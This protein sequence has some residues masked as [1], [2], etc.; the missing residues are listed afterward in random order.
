[1]N[2]AQISLGQSR[3]AFAPQGKY[4]M[5]SYLRREQG[6]G[7]WLSGFL[8]PRSA[9]IKITSISQDDGPQRKHQ[10]GFKSRADEHQ[11]APTCSPKSTYFI[12]RGKR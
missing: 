2:L 11:L 8:G 9:I 4:E 3:L 7:I 6:S 10:V 12:A 1:M 5:S